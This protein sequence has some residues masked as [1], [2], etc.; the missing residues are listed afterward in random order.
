MSFLQ[1]NVACRTVLTKHAP[2][3]IRFVWNLAL[4]EFLI[5]IKSRYLLQW[6]VFV[7][8]YGCKRGYSS[9]YLFK[10]VQK[11]GELSIAGFLLLK[12]TNFHLCVLIPWLW[13]YSLWFWLLYKQG[14]ATRT[15]HLAEIGIKTIF[16]YICL[17][18]LC[19]GRK[20]LCFLTSIREKYSLRF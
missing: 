14:N 3:F 11:L 8:A 19:S 13:F 10:S 9:A 1:A 4:G 2:L 6:S 17:H 7:A 16:H 5:V 18:I 20:K 15:R 12:I